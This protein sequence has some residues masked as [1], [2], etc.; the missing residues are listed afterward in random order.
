MPHLRAALLLGPLPCASL[1]AAVHAQPPACDTQ[2]VASDPATWDSVYPPT[3]AEVQIPS[4]GARM[5]GVLYGAQGKGPPATVLFLNGFPGDVNNAD[6]AQA[7]RRAG[8]TP[9]GC[10]YP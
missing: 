8:V 4:S 7:V 1:L 6:L 2:A 9:L 3:F 10:H 5:N